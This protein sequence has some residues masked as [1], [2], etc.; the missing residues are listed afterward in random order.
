[1]L[2]SLRCC[3]ELNLSM[4]D[5]SQIFTSVFSLISN[6]NQLNCLSISHCKIPQSIICQQ[7]VNSIILGE[8]VNKFP[9]LKVIHMQ[10]FVPPKM[11]EVIEILTTFSLVKSL[12]KLC[13]LPSIYM[14]PGNNETERE[15]AAIRIIKICCGILQ[16]K[17]RDD[18]E[19]IDL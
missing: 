7:L 14:F 8:S 6:C 15:T 5:F 17:G 12:Q 2:K 3:K 4:N 11:N 10:P 1:M 19:F 13:F 16:S 9:K 18:I